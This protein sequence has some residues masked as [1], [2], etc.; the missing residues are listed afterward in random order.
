MVH[1]GRASFIE[2]LFL[3]NSVLI[4]LRKTL[5]SSSLTTVMEDLKCFKI[6]AGRMTRKDSGSKNATTG[7][8]HE[9]HDGNKCGKKVNRK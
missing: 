8:K 4:G 6:L 1:L 9:M 5:F 3:F 7:E 2:R